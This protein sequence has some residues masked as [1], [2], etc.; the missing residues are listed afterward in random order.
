MVL[1]APSLPLSGAEKVEDVDST[2]TRFTSSRSPARAAIGNV[3][4]SARDLA[5]QHLVCLEEGLAAGD[6]GKG[7]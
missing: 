1:F 3:L 7:V 5:I 2:T 6:L 4:A